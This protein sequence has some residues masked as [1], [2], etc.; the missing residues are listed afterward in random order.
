MKNHRSKAVLVLFAGCA[1]AGVLVG[2]CLSTWQPGYRQL[3]TLNEQLRSV[4][5]GNL[6]ASAGHLE[7]YCAT[8]A[9]EDF[10]QA[11]SELHTALEAIALCGD[12]QGYRAGYDK[13]DR[14]IQETAIDYLRSAAQYMDQ[15]A[16]YLQN[17]TGANST[18][19]DISAVLQPEEPAAGGEGHVT[20]IEI[21]WNM[22][23]DRFP[24]SVKQPV[25]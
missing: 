14:I 22:R 4:I 20:F 25:D 23:D 8:G 2:L 17:A 3:K 9:V 12:Y 21:Y 11:N 24:Q 13:T 5:Y 10:E 19:R 6:D 16:P 1:L 18:L 15:H 7:Q